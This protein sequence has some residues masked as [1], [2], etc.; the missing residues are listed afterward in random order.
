[1]W[2][3]LCSNVVDK[4]SLGIRQYWPHPHN[5]GGGLN[6]SPGYSTRE[7]REAPVTAPWVGPLCV[8]IP[9]PY[10]QH[11]SYTIDLNG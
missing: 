8:R 7:I 1:M 6:L 10:H 5:A 2:Y 11:L 4:V 3:F 9:T